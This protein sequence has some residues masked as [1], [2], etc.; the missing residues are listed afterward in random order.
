MIKIFIP[1][2][3]GHYVG[4]SFGPFLILRNRDQLKDLVLINHETIH[5]YQQIEMLFIPMW[6]LYGIFYLMNRI[7][8]MNH[9]SAYKAIPF[10]KEAYS[11]E[12]DLQ[13]LFRR[14]PY[15]WIRK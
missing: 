15:S 14:M 3:L 7:K 2:L 13:Y 9:H 8:G 12:K 6:A 4:M 1:K 11:N 10:E 5:F